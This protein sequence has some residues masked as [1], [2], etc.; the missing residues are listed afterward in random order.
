METASNTSLIGKLIGWLFGC[1]PSKLVC[2]TDIAP[3][4]DP[5][6]KELN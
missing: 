3:V 4:R 2:P 1:H 6:K 5:R